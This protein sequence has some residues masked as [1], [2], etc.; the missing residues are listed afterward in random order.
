MVHKT[1]AALFVRRAEINL[2]ISLAC[3]KMVYKVIAS[4]RLARV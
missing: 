4:Y 2:S 3:N 1:K